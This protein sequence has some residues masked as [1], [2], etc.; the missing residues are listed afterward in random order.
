[1]ASGG[2]REGAG[3]KPLDG[4]T[5]SIK[6]SIRLPEKILKEI[7]EFGIGDNEAQKLRDIIEKGIRLAKENQEK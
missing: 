6:F 4:E 3:R 7:S 5:K 2:K 1:M